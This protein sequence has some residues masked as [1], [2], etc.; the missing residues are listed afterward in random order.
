MVHKTLML[1]L[2]SMRASCTMI[3]AV[4]KH[5]E[6][7]SSLLILPTPLHNLCCPWQIGAQ[8]ALREHSRHRT[9]GPR[10]TTLTATLTMALAALGN[11]APKKY[12]E[13]DAA[14][15]EHVCD[16]TI[17]TTT[18]EYE[19]ENRHYTHVDYQNHTDNIK[20]MITGAA[21]MDDAILVVFG[22]DEAAT[23]LDS[24]KN[25]NEIFLPTLILPSFTLPSFC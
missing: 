13:I 10:K 5:L 25:I 24:Q 9:L 19:T 7:N 15:K 16:I 21:Q 3:M 18:V 12:D 22:Y 2:E 1:V 14:S 6:S 20:N 11:N 8:E 23:L 17:N 4:K